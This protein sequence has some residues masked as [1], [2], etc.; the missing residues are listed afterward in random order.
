MPALPP[1]ADIWSFHPELTQLRHSANHHIGNRGITC[2]CGQAFPESA[3]IARLGVAPDREMPIRYSIFVAAGQIGMVFAVS[4]YLNSL[5]RNFAGQAVK[6]LVT[7]SAV[8]LV[9]QQV[10]SGFA[11]TAVAQ[12]YVSLW[13]LFRSGR[14]GC[15]ELVRL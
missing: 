4:G 2:C 15:K 1:K 11:A 5:C 10:A 3:G 14:V 6:S 9:A 13:E 7:L 12:K 8:I